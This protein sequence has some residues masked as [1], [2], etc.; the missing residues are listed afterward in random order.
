MLSAN[1]ARE[2]WNAIAGSVAT[3]SYGYLSATAATLAAV[4]IAGAWALAVYAALAVAPFLLLWLAP[5]R[6]LFFPYADIEGYWLQKVQIVERPYSLSRVNWR[7]FGGWRYVGV[8]FDAEG[9]VRAS[10]ESGSVKFDD[11]TEFWIFKGRSKRLTPDGD[12]ISEGNVIS[13]LYWG[14]MKK[15]QHGHARERLPGRIF[16]LDFQDQPSA[17]AMNLMRVEDRDWRS[18]EITHKAVKLPTAQ[19]AKLA[20]TVTAGEKA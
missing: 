4:A 5:V 18:A 7:L 17:A 15:R 6:R 12:P 16:D 10:W 3:L 20:A 1:R 14:E 2:I 9:V 13:V 11:A 8:A 19:L